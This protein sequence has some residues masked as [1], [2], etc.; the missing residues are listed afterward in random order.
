MLWMDV[1]WRLINKYSLA[2]SLYVII[3]I[4]VV[5]EGLQGTDIAYAGI[6]FRGM[7]A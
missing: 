2:P 7:R 1:F 6:S 4:P 5:V 3:K